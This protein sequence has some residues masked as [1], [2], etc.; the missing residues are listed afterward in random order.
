MAT[1]TTQIFL[2]ST[3]IPFYYVGEN[4]VGLFPETQTTIPTNGLIYLFDATNVGSYPGSGSQWNDLTANK[5]VASPFSSSVFPTWDNTNKEFD[6]NGTS[7]ALL[8]NISSSVATGSKITDFSQLMWMKMPTGSPNG[9]LG[10]VNLE[11]GPLNQ[12]D[13]ISFVSGSNVW[14]LQSENNVRN[15]TS[16]QIE[17]VYNQYFLI[18]ATRTSGTNNFKIYKDTN[19]IASG[20]FTP[21]TY[22]ASASIDIWSVMGQRF[23]NTGGN[24]WPSD[25][26]WSGSLS[27]V[28][29]YN[30]VLQQY[31]IEQIYN[32]GR[33][34]III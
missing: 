26:W 7:Q 17:S 25:G 14:R 20:S 11:Y 18:S 24:S 16:A 33:T 13:A 28:M 4:Q 27:S 8:A 23:Y 30:R 12:F 5:I 31:E 21:I 32:A 9:V 34:G 22:Q 3:P 10:V 19:V 6:F 29:L 15:V 2:G 1:Q